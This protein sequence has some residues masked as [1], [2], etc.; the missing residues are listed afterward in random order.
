MSKA[1]KGVSRTLFGGS[2][3]QSQQ[4]SSS[5]LDPRLFALFKENYDFAKG[6]SNN[7]G[8]RQF[9]GFT[10]DQ[11]AAFDMVRN[12]AVNGPGIATTNTAAQNV[13]NLAT[14]NPATVAAPTATSQGYNAATFGGATIAPTAMAGSQGFDAAGIDRSNIRDVAGGSF[15][16]ANI[17]QYMNPYIDEVVNTSLNDID[18][19]RV[20]QQQQVNAQAASRGAYGGSRQAIAEAENNR[21]FTDQFARTAAELRARGFDT[22]AGLAVSDMDRSLQSQLANQGV[23][24]N[25]ASTNAG[26]TQAANQFGAQ[27][28]NTAAL[29]NAGALNTRAQNQATL[30]QQ[31][32]LSN[33]DAL[34]TAG[35]FTAGAANDASMFNAGQD[36][37]AQLANQ[38]AGLTA[39]QQNLAANQL[40]AALGVQQQDLAFDAANNLAAVG[41]QQQAF[42]QQLLDAVRNLPL[43][44]LAIIS[45]ALGINPGGGSGN[46]STSSG[47]SSGSSDQGLFGAF[48]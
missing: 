17:K 31:A 12:T 21:N 13:Q 18:R 32:G 22:A 6:V 27:A 20:L 40:L 38:Q 14:F 5:M 34:N 30:D 15:L 8:T 7:L 42:D 33:A 45:G 39:N 37:Q 16:N 1:I 48:F 19:A 4:Q 46:V 2:D 35:Q 23:D 44:Q 9:A 28:A 3:Q 26:F 47:S 10:P 43:E 36:M 24:A 29:A 41:G 11:Q 25:V